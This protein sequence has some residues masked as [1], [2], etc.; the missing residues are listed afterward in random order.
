[1]ARGII[2][3]TRPSRSGVASPTEVAGDPT[4]GHVVA[5]TGRTIITVR[6]A[7]SASHTVTWVIPGKVDDQPV[8]AR[9]ASIPAGVSR[10]FGQFQIDIYGA[11]L[12]IN[13]DSAQLKLVAREP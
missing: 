10:D 4:N 2:P 3:V 12:A 1:M 11:Q 8:T 7:D 6:N 5:N 13:V 9:T